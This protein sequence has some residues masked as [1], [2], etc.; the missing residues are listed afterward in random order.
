M[1]FAARSILVGGVRFT[2][3]EANFLHAGIRRGMGVR[4]IRSVFRETFGRGLPSPSFTAARQQLSKAEL[5]GV[6]LSRLRPGTRLA[7]VNIPKVEVTRAHSRYVVTGTVRTRI[8]GTDTVLQRF[9]RFGTNE[10]PSL[11]MLNARATEIINLG[12]EQGKSDMVVEEI[13][14]FTVVEQIELSQAS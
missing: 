3:A 8:T 5:A 13:E 4:D 1:V 7:T 6:R 12:V 2:A 14:T 10:R 11:E 9:V